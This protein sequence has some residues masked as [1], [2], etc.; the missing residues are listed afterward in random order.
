MQNIAWPLGGMPLFANVCSRNW[1]AA[2]NAKLTLATDE[3]NIR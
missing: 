1:A 2:Q 3:R